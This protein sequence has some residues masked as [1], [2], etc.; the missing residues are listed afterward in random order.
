MAASPLQDTRQVLAITLVLCVILGLVAC[1]CVAIFVYAKKTRDDDDQALRSKMTAIEKAQQQLANDVSD[2]SQML[3][4]V[5]SDMADATSQHASSHVLLNASLGALT[6]S[7]VNEQQPIVIVHEYRVAVHG[8]VEN[9]CES[10]PSASS[11]QPS[12]PVNYHRDGDVNIVDITG[13]A[14]GC[15]L[16][17]IGRVEGFPIGQHDWEGRTVPESTGMARL[18]ARLER[19]AAGGRLNWLILIGR[20]DRVPLGNELREKYGSNVGLAQA[21]ATWVSQQLVDTGTSA[22]TRTPILLSAGPLNV[23]PKRCKNADYDCDAKHREKDRSVEVFACL[24]AIDGDL[25]H[26]HPDI[27]SRV[28]QTRNQP[29]TKH[30]H[31]HLPGAPLVQSIARS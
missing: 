11:T 27:G 25:D 28:P 1:S 30:L 21:R 17:Y 16:E 7:G 15:R 6:A 9:A 24:E 22:A 20:A 5:T 29:A 10:C 3:T 4:G 8:G 23:P 31:A 2:L 12:E 26:K 14:S 18:H 19:H 13:F